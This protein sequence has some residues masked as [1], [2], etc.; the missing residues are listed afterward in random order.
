[1]VHRKHAQ[2][3]IIAAVTNHIGGGCHT[4]KY[5]VLRKHYTLAR[6]GC[7]GCKDKGTHFGRIVPRIAEAIVPRK[8]LAFAL[9]GK[10]A[11]G[12]S[13]FVIGSSVE[14]DNIFQPGDIHCKEP[15]GIFTGAEHRGNTSVF[16]ECLD[17]GI[18][19][20]LIERDNDRP[21]ADDGGIGDYPFRTA[22]RNDGYLLFL[23]PEPAKRC[24]DIII[25]G[26]KLFV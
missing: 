9:E 1:M 17:L 5:V 24:A 18:H 16:K 19:Q 15:F 23:K 25:K 7:P 10:L 8:K 20:F 13:P 22:F 12:K 3:H 4:G 26:E 11:E 6:A 21:A 2:K 14:I